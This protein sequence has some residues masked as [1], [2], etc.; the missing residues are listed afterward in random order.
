MLSE[1]APANLVFAIGSEA[2]LTI[3]SHGGGVFENDHFHRS[4]ICRHEHRGRLTFDHVPG[5]CIDERH[6]RA[7]GAR[8]AIGQKMLYNAQAES[9]GIALASLLG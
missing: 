3:L 4:Y 6:L 1:D 9:G 5:G 7:I 8:E 2:V